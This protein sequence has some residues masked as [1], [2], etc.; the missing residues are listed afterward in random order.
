MN[1]F[2]NAALTGL[3][4]G[5]ADLSNIVFGGLTSYGMYRS[6]IDPFNT[7]YVNLDSPSG[8]SSWAHPS[9]ASKVNVELNAQGIDTTFAPLASAI[10]NPFSGGLFGG[11]I[12]GYGFPTST[13]VTSTT[14]LPLGAKPTI[15]FWA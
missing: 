8:F 13:F 5:A 10:T 11:G 14:Y 9:Y 4:W 3:A 1:S 15:G 6:G 12:F 2:G 7:L